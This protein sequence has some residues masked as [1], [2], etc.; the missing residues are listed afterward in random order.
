MNRY[1][2]Q[3]RDATREDGGRKWI[4]ACCREVDVS[5]LSTK[6]QCSSEGAERLELPLVSVMEWGWWEFGPST[7][8]PPLPDNLAAMDA[9]VSHKYTYCTT[10]TVTALLRVCGACLSSFLT[11]LFY[12]VSGSYESNGVYKVGFKAPVFI[13]PHS[14]G[15][16]L[17]KGRICGSP[18]VSTLCAPC[19]M[20]VFAAC[21]YSPG[22]LTSSRSITH[23]L[24]QSIFSPQQ[25]CSECL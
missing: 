19:T 21:T 14:A 22:S 1:E 7:R 13:F 23:Q 25:I 11:V 3:T 5:S 17:A 9:V 16:R 4:L 10:V 2:V 15:I 20:T 6:V 12:C 8:V 18:R 24:P